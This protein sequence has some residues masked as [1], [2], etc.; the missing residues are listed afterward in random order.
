MTLR[1]L[2]TQIPFDKILPF[3]LKG[4]DSSAVYCYKQAYDILLHT[5]P[6]ENGCK[7]IDVNMR[8]DWDGTKY[9]S[10]S[11]IEGDWWST[12][13][14]GEIKLAD[15]V[16]ISDEELAYRL[17]WHLTF[18]GFSPE[19]IRQTIEGLGNDGYHDNIYGSLAREIERKRTILWANKEIRKRIKDSIV[20]H[21]NQGLNSIYLSEEDWNYIENHE[22]HCNRMKRMRD[23]RLALRLE[24]LENKDRSENT[25]QRL[26][27]GQIETKVTREELSFLGNTNSR[28]GSEFQ[29]LS[30]CVEARL[31][32][33]R[34]L[35]DK[36]N[37][38]DV[39]Y[40]TDRIVVRVSASS[41]HPITE[42]EFRSIKEIIQS[43]KA[44]TNSLFIKA[45]DDK[46]NEEIALMAV[47]TSKCQESQ[48]RQK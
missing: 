28:Y 24:D 19:E 23:H 46:L 15:D 16:K 44:D 6:H 42:Q 17:L 36:Y 45:I 35:I 14:D 2:F 31:D 26:L 37:A 29:S 41:Q 43:K 10:A 18:Y 3:I 32:Y 34:E 20:F 9:V 38:L 47:G 11:Q 4:K 22:S 39:I 40:K 8:V 25:I 7:D 1:N 48:A 5:D 21:A 13:I 30:Y 27:K 33:V 12:Y